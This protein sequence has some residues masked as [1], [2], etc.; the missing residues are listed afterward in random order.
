MYAL[1]EAMS[2]H[3]LVSEASCSSPTS[4]VAD[5]GTH[6]LPVP[7]EMDN[8]SEKRLRLRL[9]VAN[10][11]QRGKVDV[12]VACTLQQLKAAIQE[13]LSLRGRGD[14]DVS[15]DKKVGLRRLD[16]AF[17][18]VVQSACERPLGWRLQS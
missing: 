11:P 4:S 18:C 10:A 5:A 6:I 14:I 8:G 16:Q 2:W 13:Q 9:R 7:S 15:L 3:Q 17:Q 12:P 1:P